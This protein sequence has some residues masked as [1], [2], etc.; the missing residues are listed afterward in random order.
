MT[1]TKH[2]YAYFENSTTKIGQTGLTDVTFYVAS[3]RH[4]DS[5]VATVV[6]G[7]VGFE[8]IR[9]TYAVLV[10]NMDLET[11]DYIGVAQTAS[12]A[13]ISKAAPLLRWD[14]AESHDTELANLDA[15]IS[16]RSTLVAGA[17]M[18]LVDELK[19]IASTSGFDRTTDSLEAVGEK[20]KNLPASPAVAGEAAAAVVGLAVQADVESA[21]TAAIPDISGLA[22]S[23]S[24]GEI[25]TIADK[26]DSAMEDDG[27][28]S[29]FTENALEQAPAGSVTVEVPDSIIEDIWTYGRRTWTQPIPSYV[30][31]I[32]QSKLTFTNNVTFDQDLTGL[33]I[34][35][36]W[37]KIIMTV[38]KNKSTPDTSALFQWIVSNPPDADDGLVRVNSIA[39]TGEDLLHG[40]LSI[41]QAAGKIRIYIDDSVDVA[42]K[43]GTYSFDIK[44]LLADGTSELLVTS[45]LFIV[46][47][48][49]TRRVDPVVS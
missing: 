10:P 42:S 9:G 38:K 46:V 2:V 16:T 4:S 20:V 13:V 49:E 5:A 12:T 14:A 27:V 32:D 6:N 36:T 15:A 7:T 44:A 40:Y 41:D 35:A 8:V 34:S 23:T 33:V 3:V 24:I 22:T 43:Y 31:Q 19:H 30:A 1:I 26:L 18:D 47:L 17:K 45:T 11:Y 29:R 25:K 48:T 39:K 37:S 21:I 28:V